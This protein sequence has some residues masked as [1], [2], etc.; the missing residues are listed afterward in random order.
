MS[1]LSLTS[2]SRVNILS[3]QVSIFLSTIFRCFSPTSLHINEVFR[4]ST[5]FP[6]LYKNDLEIAHYT[7]YKVRYKFT[8]SA[9]LMRTFFYSQHGVNKIIT[10]NYTHIKFLDHYFGSSYK[11]VLGK[12][13]CTCTSMMTSRSFRSNVKY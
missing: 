7:N 5:N 10:L 12:K 1:L 2:H 9:F 6:I 8:L 11:K 4:L 3:R 13:I